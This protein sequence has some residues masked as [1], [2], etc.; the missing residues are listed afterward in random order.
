[1]NTKSDGNISFEEFEQFCREFP[2]AMDFLGKITL[3]Q[4]PEYEGEIDH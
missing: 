4:Y 2:S 1:M 3:D